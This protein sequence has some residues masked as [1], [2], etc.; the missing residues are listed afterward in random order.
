MVSPFYSPKELKNKTTGPV[1]FL[2]RGVVLLVKSPLRQRAHSPLSPKPRPLFLLVF[3]KP[4]KQN[5]AQIAFGG[6]GQDGYDGFP[7]KF[8]GFPEANCDR[9]SSSGRNACQD[10][11]LAS[12]AAGHLDRFLIRNQFDAIHHAE[13]EGVRNKTGANALNLVGARTDGLTR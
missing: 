8:R 3:K 2:V 6:I 7:G 9:R 10:A 1:T 4:L 5:G 13:V 12:E 11:F